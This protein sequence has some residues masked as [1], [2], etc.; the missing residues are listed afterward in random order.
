MQITLAFLS[1]ELT[2]AVLV[3][4]QLQIGHRI[5]GWPE[6]SGCRLRVLI[7][8]RGLVGVGHLPNLQLGVQ[9]A[10]ALQKKAESETFRMGTE[11]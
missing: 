5:A 6:I 2:F 4:V 11:P 10:P 3:V 8:L 7:H 1:T 9:R